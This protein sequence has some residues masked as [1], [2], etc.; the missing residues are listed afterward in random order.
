MN[1]NCSQTSNREGA[2]HARTPRTLLAGRVCILGL[3]VLLFVGAVTRGPSLGEKSFWVDEVFTAEVSRHGFV[4]AVNF[5]K[6]DVT[7][8]LTYL[9]TCLTAKFGVT[10]MTIRLPSF[11]SGLIG[12][13]AMVWLGAVVLKRPLGG[14]VAGALVTLSPLHLFHSQDA[15]MY[16]AFIAFTALALGCEYRFWES[17][18]RSPGFTRG[19]LTLLGGWTLA[20]Y[21]NLYTTYFAFFPLAGQGLHVLY[22]LWRCRSD[23]ERNTLWLLWACAL[24]LVALG[25]L[26]WLPTLLEFVGRN[27]FQYGADPS[28]KWRI[29]RGAY[30]TF[31]PQS[32]FGDVLFAVTAAVGFISH[33][34]L[35]RLAVCQTVPAAIYLAVFHTQHFFALRY[36]AFL[37]P[38]YLLLVSAGLSTWARWFR[39]E[40][41][42]FGKRQVIY[43]LACS[44]T[45]AAVSW[46]GLARYYNYPKQDWRKAAAFVQERLQSGDRIITGKNA[47]RTSLRHYFRRNPASVKATIRGPIKTSRQLKAELS[48]PGRIW[49]VHAWRT[50]TSQELLDTIESNFSYQR[51]YPA[52]TDWGEIFIFLRESESAAIN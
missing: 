13:A 25:Y 44:L 29:L 28:F 52:L 6:G 36:L 31:G 15:R 22:Q 32:S 30:H 1:N 18:K 17:W 12:I 38:V 16:S 26:P 33:P 43:W 47:A 45:V 40:P 4:Q 41:T 14:L 50:S 8:P 10:E 5:A 42:H 27:P 24:T 21:A 20:V 51:K 11:L 3:M 35:R 46:P 48:E 37:L 9:W 34:R 2:S 23:R 7:P 19:S 39:A 49:F